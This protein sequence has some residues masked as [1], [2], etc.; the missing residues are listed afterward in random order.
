LKSRLAVVTV[1]TVAI[2]CAPAAQTRVSPRP[3]AD[4]GLP[5]ESTPSGVTAPVVR[6]LPILPLPVPPSER[7]RR[8][9]IRLVVD[10]MGQAVR[11]SVTVC[12]IRDSRYAE[13]VAEKMAMLPFAPARRDGRPITWPTRIVV[14]IAPVGRNR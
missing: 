14:Q 5:E 6:G 13:L 7:G 2:G 10:T 8:V 1:L 11:D 3:C 4:D 9:T 12:G